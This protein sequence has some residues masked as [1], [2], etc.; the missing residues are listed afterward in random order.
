MEKFKIGD[1]IRVNDNGAI[2]DT[3]SEK[4]KELGFKNTSFNLGIK[5][6][7]FAKIFA[8]SNHKFKCNTILLACISKKGKEFLID[9]DGVELI[10]R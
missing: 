7:K 6:G 1:I 4:F 2:Y 3:F 5:N 8:I 9:S 10:F